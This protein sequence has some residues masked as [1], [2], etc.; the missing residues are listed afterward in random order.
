MACKRSSVRSRSGSPIIPTPYGLAKISRIH[1]RGQSVDCGRV[2]GNPEL[3]NEK[4]SSPD[5]RSLTT[6]CSID[7]SWRSNPPKR[8]SSELGT[9]SRDCAFG[10]NSPESRLFVQ[11]ESHPLEI[12]KPYG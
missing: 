3:T 2:T 7:S 11:V 5:E 9:A 6:F 4:P 8:N 12:S 1:I 10:I